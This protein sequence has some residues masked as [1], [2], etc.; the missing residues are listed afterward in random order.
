[1]FGE[2]LVP[3]TSV[4]IFTAVIITFYKSESNNE[5]QSNWWLGLIVKY[6]AYFLVYTSLCIHVSLSLNFWNVGM[7]VMFT[8]QF[9]V[10]TKVMFHISDKRSVIVHYLKPNIEEINLWHQL[11]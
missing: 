11:L 4:M 10:F 3:L 5:N 8:G 9:L 2:F 7:F 6:T 1:M